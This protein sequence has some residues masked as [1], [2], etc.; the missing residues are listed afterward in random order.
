MLLIP[1]GPALKS[2]SEL[3]V[4]VSRATR[5]SVSTLSSVTSGAGKTSRLSESLPSSVAS[6]AMGPSIV[7]TGHIDSQPYRF[8]NPKVS[9]VA[10]KNLVDRKTLRTSL[11]IQIMM[12]AARINK[13]LKTH[14]HAATEIYYILKGRGQMILGIGKDAERVDLKPGRFIYLPSNV[15][16]QTVSDAKNP[17]EI[18]YIFPRNEINEVEYKFHDQGRLEGA[19]KDRPIIG[20]L[21]VLEEYPSSLTRQTLIEK[22]AF[23]EN[24]LMMEHLSLP[25]GEHFQGIANE[26][27]HI[28]FVRH[29]NGFMRLG[30]Q[31]RF[32]LITGS[33]VYV[34]TGDVYFIETLDQGIDLLIFK[35]LLGN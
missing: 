15:P 10:I 25:K 29:G 27:S 23:G 33:Y 8:W 13:D 6:S 24:G 11:I 30:G 26:S 17:V 31:K 35:P 4:P 19:S 7:F 16:H 2:S 28:F 9:S 20:D 5:S 12:G 3:T 18:I 14:H 34:E 21:S 32:E 1:Q 22:R